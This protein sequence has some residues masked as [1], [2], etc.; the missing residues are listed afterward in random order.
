MAGQLDAK[1]QMMA[2]LARGWRW[3]DAITDV[4]VHPS[5]HGLTV[6][7]NRADDTL[8]MSAALVAA[9]ELVIPTPAGL[10]RRFWRDEQKKVEPSGAPRQ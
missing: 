9:L 3:R 4:L 5:D 8:S 7:Y 2:L 6:T 1:Q 10:N